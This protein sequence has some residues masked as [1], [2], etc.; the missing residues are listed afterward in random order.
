MIIIESHKKLG[1]KFQI[2]KTAITCLY[3]LLIVYRATMRI[4]AYDISFPFLFYNKTSVPGVPGVP[5]FRY[6]LLIIN[7]MQAEQ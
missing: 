6:S 3:V 1:Y 7:Q 4:A 2:H 5:V